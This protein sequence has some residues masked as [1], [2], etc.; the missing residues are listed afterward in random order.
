[1]IMKHPLALFLD[2][3]SPGGALHAAAREGEAKSIAWLL[4]HNIYE[5]DCYYHD[6]TALYI[7][8][9]RNQ[10]ASILTLLQHKAQPNLPCINGRFDSA[11]PIQNCIY[12]ADVS[13]IKLLIMH[14]ANDEGV[15]FIQGRQDIATLFSKTLIT[16]RRHDA[17]LQEAK[18]QLSN[19]HYSQAL[20]HYLQ[21]GD[22]WYNLSL[23]EPVTLYQ[24][25]YQ[26]QALDLYKKAIHCYEKLSA[27]EF[28]QELKVACQQ[29]FERSADCCHWLKLA[30]EAKAYSSQAAR[31]H[32]GLRRQSYTSNSEASWPATPIDVGL[33]KRKLR[34][35]TQT[36]EQQALIH[37]AYTL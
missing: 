35:P 15:K 31:L 20:T 36:E 27:V 37:N 28:S 18:A 19:K 24:H 17:C 32:P 22:V 34:R 26:E 8:I 23:N 10:P 14:G 29:L 4:D 21:A 3:L 30:D 7:A 11:K 5:V 16:K 9:L 33:Y 2:A 12:Q 6:L 25:Y 1:M 13:N